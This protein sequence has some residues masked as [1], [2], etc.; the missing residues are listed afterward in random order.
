M[1]CITDA[2]SLIWKLLALLPLGSYRMTC[3]DSTGEYAS[4]MHYIWTGVQFSTCLWKVQGW[5]SKQEEINNIW[6]CSNG[7]GNSKKLM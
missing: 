5:S 6:T 2:L 1:H 4:I 3:L 7:D